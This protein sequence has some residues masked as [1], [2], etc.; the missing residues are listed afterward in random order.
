MIMTRDHMLERFYARDRA[1]NGRFIT[2]V[3]TTGIYCLPSCTARK[4]LPENVRFFATREDARSA[5]LRPCR[6]CRPDDFYQQYDPDIHLLQTLLG[7]VR[8]RPSTFA[9]A[10]AL[11]AASGIGTTKLNALF[12]QHLHT[13]PAAFLARERVAAACRALAEGAAVTEAAFA[14]GFESLSAFHL[15]FRRQTGLTPGEYRALG[16]SRA[17][18]L[19]LPDGFRADAVL[20]YH[21]RDPA[22]RVERVCGSEMVKA[23]RLGDA[24][25]RLRIR[26]DEGA[27]RCEVELDA[28]P[29]PEQMREA[30]AAAVRMLNL[31]SDPSPFERQLERR[32]ELARLIEPRRGLRMPLTADAWECLVWTIVGQQVNLP[33]AFALRGVVAELAGEDAGD[34]L[35]AHPTP[36][37]VARLDHADLTRRR[38]SGRKAE[39]V[40]DT[41]RLIAGGELRID[42]G[43]RELVPALERRLLAVRG[44][45][46]WSVQYLLMRGY[47]FADCVP[48]GDAGLSAALQRFFSLDHRPGPGETRELMEPFAPFRSL[49][50]C[51]LWTTLGDSQ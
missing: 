10:S 17:F 42:A 2:G 50:T 49:A 36:E 41:A 48:A 5:G 30:H 34:G 25:V 1:S 14:A 44:L 40:I 21:G 9:D 8:R 35:R 31:A 24:P 11:V 45:G 19:A 16:S 15:N 33:F 23:L 47:G 51:H 3:L 38:F 13:T 12:R 29:S 46:P 20:A 28:A 43:E 32:P 39:Y 7:D 22:S 6:R 27:A 26:F 4:P 37:A 18:T